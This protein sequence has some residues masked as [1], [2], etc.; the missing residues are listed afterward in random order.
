MMKKLGFGCMRLP[1]LGADGKV[2]IPQFSRMVDELFDECHNMVKQSPEL[3]KHIR[4]RKSDLYYL[5]TMSKL[6]PLSRNSDSL[7]GLNASFVIM[8]ELHG[9]KDRN[10]YEFMRQ[11]QAAR[12]V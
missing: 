1:T 8:D 3:S 7:V 6:Q 4:K 10:L 9:V 12:I 11:S 2:D 5:P